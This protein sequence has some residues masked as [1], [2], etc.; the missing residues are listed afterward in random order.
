M[1]KYSCE[2]CGKEFSQKGHYT[3]HTTKKNPCVFESKIE[4]IIEKVIAKKI[5]EI[6]INEIK[7]NEEIT[8]NIV[9]NIKF[10]DL[11][12]GIGS[13]H[14]SFKK[15]GWDC[16]MSCDI[17]NA[18]KETYKNNYG[19][20]PL[21]DIT[22]IEPKNITN[23]DI[24][25]AGFPCQPFSQCGQHKGFDDKRGTLFFNI[26]KF[27]DYHKPKVIIL[28]NVMGLLNHDGGKTFEKIKGD[29][30]TSNYSITYK[31]IKCSD[32]GLPQMRKRLIIVGVRND[33]E[34]INHIDKLL[35]LD[36]Y[37]KET[38][39]TELLG[40]NFEKKIAYTIRCGGKNSPID[41]KHN[42]DGYMVDGKEYRLTK[43]DC[44]KIQGFSSDFK[45]CG[46]NKDQWKQLGN[47]IPTIFT[48]IIGLN[49]K[50]YL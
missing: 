43:E 47:T 3:K 22:E 5:N 9:E 30:E 23:Y 42:W 32:Y 21:G 12:C 15:L 50:K 1:V 48:E 40:K 34:L 36:E 41:D 46:N 49:L 4:E 38:T 45:L 25:C 19:I 8:E 26:M 28:E 39:L 44:L 6:K 33:T 2:K 14:Y 29:I 13:F 16:V 10:I 35:D 11:F 20:S 17:D 18:V 24:L 37:K 31:V 7:I 27:V